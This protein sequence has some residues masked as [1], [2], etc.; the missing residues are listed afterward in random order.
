VCFAEES[1]N[2]LS[3]TGIKLNQTLCHPGAGRDLCYAQK[4]NPKNS[5]VYSGL[6]GISPRSGRRD[7]PINPKQLPE[8]ILS[9]QEPELSLVNG[10][11]C[12]LIF[13]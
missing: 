9:E 5:Q 13:S 4:R 10:K 11:Y 3:L 1:M 12:E 8:K 6:S 7:P 2:K